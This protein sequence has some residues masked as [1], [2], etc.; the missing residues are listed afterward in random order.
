MILIYNPHT[1]VVSFKY[2]LSKEIVAFSWQDDSR[3]YVVSGAGGVGSPCNGEYRRVRELND[4]P[5][6]LGSKP[7]WCGDF[8]SKK[9]ER[10][11][12]EHRKNIKND[13]N[14]IEPNDAMMPP[15]NNFGQN[16]FT[17]F[18]CW[19]IFYDFLTRDDHH[20]LYQQCKDT[21]KDA[22]AGFQT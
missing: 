15:R 20:E 17:G 9:G 7:V 14:M 19:R 2:Q 5:L 22:G 13:R 12:K 4:K 8:W 16:N 10:L 6:P 18:G 11:K 1:G 3:V 21:H